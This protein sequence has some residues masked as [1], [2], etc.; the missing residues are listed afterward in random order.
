VFST[1]IEARGQR[2]FLVVAPVQADKTKETIEE[3]LAEIKSLLTNKPVTSD[4]YQNARRSRVNQLPALW[5]TMA[6][7][8]SSLV[9][10]VNFN[11]PDDYFEKYPARISSLKIGDLNRAAKQVLHPES[12]IWVVVGDRSKLEKP[13]K[14]LGLGEIYFLDADGHLIK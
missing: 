7:V 2:P 13:L 5:E 9:E 11:L 10:L 8:E 4:E 1:L 6:G 14:E 3:I 12:L